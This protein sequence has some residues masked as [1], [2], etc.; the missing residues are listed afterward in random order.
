MVKKKRIL[1]GCVFCLVFS[2]FSQT[3]EIGNHYQSTTKGLRLRD[4]QENGNIID[5]LGLYEPVT[6][7]S[8]GSRENTIDS[9]TEHWLEVQTAEGQ[10]GWCFGGYISK[11]SPDQ[12]NMQAFFR[13]DK[14]SHQLYSFYSIAGQEKRFYDEKV[15]L[16]YQ[17]KEIRDI[18]TIS[19]LND[20]ETLI[21]TSK[22]G[23]GGELYSYNYKTG[24]IAQ[25]DSSD[26]LNYRFPSIICDQF[27]GSS[28][29]YYTKNNLSYVYDCKTGEK[30]S[31]NYP[32]QG[33]TTS[34]ALYGDYLYGYLMDEKGYPTCR[35][36][37]VG[38][39]AYDFVLLKYIEDAYSSQ[40]FFNYTYTEIDS[41]EIKGQILNRYLLIEEYHY[42]SDNDETS[43]LFLLDTKN[44][45]ISPFNN[46]KNVIDIWLSNGEEFYT[47]QPVPRSSGNYGL[48][49]RPDGTWGA[50][51]GPDFAE[52]N[53]S[54]YNHDFQKYSTQKYRLPYTGNGPDSS[55]LGQKSWLF[56]DILYQFF[57]YNDSGPQHYDCYIIKKGI[58]SHFILEKG[59]NDSRKDYIFSP[60]SY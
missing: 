35:E 8:I 54:V 4:A 26:G 10:K 20:G 36:N 38:P 55:I 3:F 53:V 60:I 21:F 29:F 37:A 6:L 31:F 16:A 47:W 7:I 49:I 30:Y 15:I 33:Y 59:T 19:L 45:Q 32:N 44:G 41:R 2:L 43:E 56:N 58:F 17:G 13:L 27:S 39:E 11:D 50:S 52:I 23:D 9:I 14:E 42:E 40:I 22:K 25:I 48:M 46:D 1:S 18:G 28:R 12:V 5:S 57:C 34:M 51:A 24:V